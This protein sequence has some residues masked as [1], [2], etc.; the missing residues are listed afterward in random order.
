VIRCCGPA[1]RESAHNETVRRLLRRLPVVV[2]AA[3]KCGRSKLSP[4]RSSRSCPAASVS[5]AP[6]IASIAPWLVTTLREGSLRAV[7]R[8]TNGSVGSPCRSDT[9]VSAVRAST[10]CSCVES[11][12]TA[13]ACSW[14]MR[15]AGP[16]RG[17]LRPSV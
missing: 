6:K 1:W 10:S 9:T 2:V 4:S 3:L 8:A 12:Q 17:W 15:N 14:F 5:S 11:T 13:S 16:A 7:S